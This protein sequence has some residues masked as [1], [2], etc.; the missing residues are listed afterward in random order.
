[1][2][3]GGRLSNET[4]QVGSFEA[5]GILG[6]KWSGRM[7]LNLSCFAGV[8]ARRRNP[9]RREGP[10][11]KEVVGAN[12]FEPSTSWSRTRR[13]SQAALRPDRQAR[14]E[15]SAPSRNIRSE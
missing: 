10:Q 2:S 6:T 8:G 5:P 14:A 15:V 7:D 12:G 1:M 11:P 13:A 9:E 4:I 3:C